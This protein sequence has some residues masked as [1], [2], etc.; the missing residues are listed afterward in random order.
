MKTIEILLLFMVKRWYRITGRI[1]ILAYFLVIIHQ[2]HLTQAATN[3]VNWEIT[4]R[5]M[6]CKKLTREIIGHYSLDA[7]ITFTKKT[8]SDQRSDH[9]CQNSKYLN[10]RY[11][12]VWN[13]A[14]LETCIY[15][16]AVLI[17][18]T[19]VKPLHTDV[20][21]SLKCNCNF[22][23]HLD[24]K[25]PNLFVNLTVVWRIIYVIYKKICILPDNTN[26]KSFVTERRKR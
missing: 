6:L 18:D 20:A 16:F 2:H 23:Y 9:I 25:E 1:L 26:W 7:S 10:S 14:L 15:S 19:A 11:K 8:S 24:V 21:V 17:F 3:C 13:R 12:P 4:L 22:N 5:F